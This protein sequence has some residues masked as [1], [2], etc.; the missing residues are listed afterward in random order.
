MTDEKQEHC[1]IQHFN[2]KDFGYS[3]GEE[4][5]KTTEEDGDD[6]LQIPSAIKHQEQTIK[7]EHWSDEDTVKELCMVNGVSHEYIE[8]E[9]PDISSLEIFLSGFPRMV[10]LSFFPNLC[11]LTIVGQKITR[12]EGLD[13]CPLLQELWV[14]QCCLTSISGLEKCEELDK[15][16]LYDNQIGEINNLESL[17]NLEVLWLNNNRMCHIQG[18]STL[19]NLKE[20]NLADNSIEKIGHSLDH[21][22]SLENLNL[23]GNKISSFKDLTQLACLPHLK[24]LTLNDP[25]STPNPVCLLSNYATHVLY[26]MP[27]LQL[28][29]TY[30]VSS[31]QI[32]EAAESTVVKKVMYYNMRARI[33]RRN[34]AETQVQL[35]ERKKVL[36]QL[37]EKYIRI[38]SHALKNYECELPKVLDS[39]KKS[40]CMTEDEPKGKNNVPKGSSDITVGEPAMEPTMQNKMEA[41]RKRL[42]DWMRR[43]QEIESSYE[44]DLA[45]AKTMMDYTIQFLVMELES[46]GNIQLEEGCP[47]DPW[48]NSCCD[49]LLSSFSLSDYRVYSITGIKIDRV[50]R[51]VNRALRLRFEDKLLSLLA[52]DDSVDLSQNQRHQLEYLFYIADPEKNNEK[53]DILS[54]LEEGFKT[55]EYKALGKE[56]A[57]ALSNS[58]IVTDQP[59]IEHTLSNACQC[60][61]MHSED[62]LPFRHG[63]IIISKV[64]VGH[65]MSVQERNVADR[66]RHPTVCSVYHS[67]DSKHRTIS[68][69]RRQFYKKPVSQKPSD[70]FTTQKQWFVFDH[71]L[72]LP[73]YIVY[74]QYLTK[75]QEHNTDKGVTSENLTIDEHVLSMEPK[76]LSLEDKILTNVARASVLSQITVLNLYGNSLNKIKIS[77]LKALRHLTISFN[78]FT[79]LDDISL[80]PKLEILDVSFNHL[81]TLEG[82]R[83]LKRLKQLD[84][85]WNKLTKARADAEVLRIQTPAL[86]KLDTRY[87]PW[88]RPEAVRMTILGHLTTLTHLDDM[89]VTEGEAAAAVDMA[90]W[91]K[92]NQASLL[93]HSR[94]D[95]DRPRSLCMLSTAQLLLL[96]SPAPWGYSHELQPD[97]ASKITVLNLDSQGISKL[98][99]L[100]Q[101]VNLRWAS[102]NNNDISNL[103]GLE[104]CLGLEELSLNNNSISTLNGLSKLQSL[105][106]LSVDRNQLSSLESLVLEQL[107]NLSF[108]SV[109][110]NFITSLHGIQRVNS[111]RELYIGSNQISTSRDIFYLKALTNLI[112]LDFYGN[113]LV[114]KQENYRFYVVFHLPSL[115]ALDGT[116]VKETECESAQDMFGGR[117]TSNMVAEKLDHSNFTDITYLSLK[118][119]SIRSADLSPA[120]QFKS[121]HTISLD[122]NNLTSFSGLIYLPNIKVLYL[123]YNHIESILPRQKTQ[124]HLT[125]KHS[126]YGNVHSSGYGQHSN[127]ENVPVVCL[128]PL[129]SS[130]EVLHL[131]HNGISCLTH[132]ELSRLTNL[133][134]LYLQD[135][136]IN[137]VEGLQGLRQLKELVL[138][139]NHI[140]ALSKNSF[141]A[142]NVLE[143]LH[144]VGNRIRELNY[145]YPLTKLRKLF[146]GINKLQTLLELEKLKVL[147]YLTELSVVGNPVTQSSFYRPEVVFHLSQLQILDGV[148]ITLEERTRV[149]LLNDDPSLFYHCPGLPTPTTDLY[150]PGLLPLL[151]M[152]PHLKGINIS[153][154]LRS[155]KPV[156]TDVL[157]NQQNDVTLKYIGTGSA[158]PNSDQHHIL[159]PGASQQFPHGG[160]PSSMWEP[161][162]MECN[163]TL[164]SANN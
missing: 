50:I 38:L 55:T 37:P 133:K 96:I 140:K 153:G 155:F 109:E 47:T 114:E 48:F 161:D 67:V 24:V 154:G 30:D 103:E 146:L 4:E 125:K 126:L 41:L 12:I 11:Q 113:P 57:I 111:L 119:C 151:P 120:D 117:L 6:I 8:L 122:H 61:S 143:E 19:Q 159:Q 42:T 106:K 40:T 118:S 63:Q 14:A 93:A 3:G 28:L 89:M 5:A 64:F 34:L 31:M 97:W 15:L 76:L 45:Q 94:I 135:N 139:R 141:I 80:M 124:A 18:L 27:D 108:L 83:G 86:L 116:A 21:N 58:L 46:V 2:I 60:D 25:T 157:S 53:E 59:R 91:S 13:C 82:L 68:D 152:S 100:N 158:L 145:L 78:E 22:V 131:G 105:N 71:E 95:G 44:Q 101:L 127:K 33:A 164:Q 130:L 90:A 99:D 39:V 136:K 142:Q 149:E 20:L 23:S 74:F 69:E 102:F 115:E 148:M 129:M 79:H 84:V 75:N 110:N 49:L 72:V 107:T 54:I 156:H 1:W 128:E 104:D 32:K 123:N 121:L 163:D 98:I 7:E 87:N 36:L 85:R 132:L 150:L 43:L 112:I 65:S 51:I 92:M 29:D 26:H 9:G 160:K 77:S 138:D 147:H 137:H 35:M 144:L 56:G 10:G 70:R 81:V 52:S 62:A 66:S 16:Y 88:H 73:E 134:V 162:G 17:I